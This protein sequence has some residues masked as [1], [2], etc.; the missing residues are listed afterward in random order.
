[1]SARR[2]ESPELNP[3]LQ[4]W[5]KSDNK[6]DRCAV[7]SKALFDSQMEGENARAEALGNTQRCAAAK[8]GQTE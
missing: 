1:M 8:G 2:P 4:I 3:T 7:H 6:V 5:G